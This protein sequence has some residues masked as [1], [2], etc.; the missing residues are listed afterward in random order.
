MR[1]LWT[2]PYLPWPT[3]SGGK[4]RQ[5]QLLRA[6][7]QRGHRITLLVQSKTGLTAAAQAQLAPLLERLICLPRR[8]LRHPKTLCATLFGT[9]PL[10][11]CVNGFAPRLREQFDR[12]LDEP[13]DVVQIEHS[14]ACQPFL[15]VLQ[16]RRRPFVLTE[17]N[18]ESRLSGA[19]YNKLPGWLAPLAHYDRWRYQRWE[20]QVLRR[21]HCIVAVSADDAAA[22]AQISGRPTR[23]V[24]NGVDGAAFAGV[25]P[26]PTSRRV[27]FVGNYEYAP[28]VD[29]VEWAVREILPRVWQTL[30]E[31]R[32]AVCGFAL[33]A[34]WRHQY[35]DPRIE[36]HGYIDSLTALQNQSALF[37]AP[38]RD[39][40]GSKLKVLEA[41]AA[42]L[43]LVSTAQG[44]SGLALQAGTHFLGGDSADALASQIAYALRHTEQARRIGCAGRA[45]VAAAYD[46][47]TVAAQLEAVYQE[48]G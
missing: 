19:T 12:L 36:W 39:G 46:W 32:F 34:R 3:T 5:Y 41:L 13:W 2:V 42:S 11:A 14:Y 29:A 20:Q 40:G 18:V 25:A 35:P 7:A 48:I 44:V 9:P 24:T 16:R 28:N 45:A 6:L 38:L 15:S 10:L 27:L 43:P 23:V 30:P 33:P 21:A 8:P 17:H 22:L 26:D 1:I 4:L 37:L 31:V 47:Q